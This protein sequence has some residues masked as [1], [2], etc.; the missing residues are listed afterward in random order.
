MRSLCIAEEY[1]TVNS[2]NVLS[3]EERRFYG[4][5]MT[6]ETK[7]NV[8]NSSGNVSCIFG[9][10]LIK[11]QFS[12]QIFIEVRNIK[13]HGNPSRRMTDMA[14]LIMAFRVMRTGLKV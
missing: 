2:I 7:K 11:F 12:Q 9:Q 13:C 10:F 4:E 8:L 3:D 6:L 1:V 5:Y 14:K